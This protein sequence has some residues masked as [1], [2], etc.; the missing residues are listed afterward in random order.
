LRP[1][2]DDKPFLSVVIPARNEEK[3]VGRTCRAI[4]KEFETA[5]IADYE[6]IVVNDHSSDGTVDVLRELSRSGNRFRFVDNDGSP[7]FGMAIQRG[8][9]AF[10]GE[11]VC[12]MMADLS[13]S[14]SDLLC[15]YRELKAGAECVFG[16][17]FIKGAK[18][19]DYPPHKLVLNR[20]ANRFIKL[21]F[22]IDHNDITNAFKAYHREVIAGI[23]PLLSH[24]FNLTVEMPLKAIVRGYS[25]KTVPVSWTNREEG[26]SKLKIKEMGSRYLFIILYAW[27]EKTLSR[28]DYRRPAQGVERR[29]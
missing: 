15:Y 3:N 24:H 27:L 29:K 7:G 14:A 22:R 20:L 16:S 8:L 28:G 18:V 13:D 4:E 2:K 9:E 6:V 11:A 21:I 10:R 26:T 19:V 23:G 12:V 25:Y 17:R 5:G 1:T